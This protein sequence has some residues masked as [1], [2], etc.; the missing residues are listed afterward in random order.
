MARCRKGWAWAPR[1][2]FLPPSPHLHTLQRH[3]FLQ[4]PTGW[5]LHWD[6]D[7]GPGSVGAPAGT[8]WTGPCLISGSARC[9]AAGTAGSGQTGPTACLPA[10]G[11]N[12][13]HP[14]VLT[15]L[16]QVPRPGG[17]QASARSSK[18][19]WPARG[20]L[21]PRGLGLSSHARKGLGAPQ[22]GHPSKNPPDTTDRSIGIPRPVGVR[23]RRETQ[24]E[25]D[26]TRASCPH[27]LSPGCP[28]RPGVCV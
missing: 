16:P 4:K 5:P 1:P 12:A 17:T 9:Q 27:T 24:R 15:R 21:A 20:S 11:R 26:G 22:G 18:A 2:E 10:L 23:S 3:V 13:I 14:P 8:V 19:W 25:T 6:L 28:E 7:L